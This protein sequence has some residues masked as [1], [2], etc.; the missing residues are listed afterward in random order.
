[1]RSTIASKRGI[2]SLFPRRTS[3]EELDRRSR[4][5]FEPVIENTVR[6]IVD[7]VRER[8]DPALRAYAEE[9]D[10]LPKDSDLYLSRRRLKEAFESLPEDDRQRLERVSARIGSF[11]RA[12]LHSLT[13]LEMK[14]PGGRAGHRVVP[15]ERAGCYAP[16]GRYPLPSSVLMTV[17]PAQ[18]AGVR[19]IWVASPDQSPLTLAAA[20]IAGACGM[21]AAGGAHAI[22]ALAFG[23]GPVSAMDL[24]VGPGN[25]YVTAAKKYVSGEVRIDMLAG[26]SELV[27][28][29]DD[30]ADPAIVAA[31]LLAQAEH[32]DNAFPFLI[33]LNAALISRVESQLE[34]QLKGLPSSDTARQALLNGGSL[35]APDL[36]TAARWSDELAPEHLQLCTRDPRSL[37][38]QLSHYGALFVG[39]QTAEV[40]GDYGAGPNHVLPTNG[41]SRSTGGLSVFTFLRIQ[42]WMELDPAERSSQLLDDGAWFARQEGLEAHARAIE[43]RLDGRGDS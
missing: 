13:E 2:E 34:N 9:L 27:I 23:A 32:D 22:A 16:G 40:M 14:I 42:T 11:A 5:I 37:A 35:L 38:D 12:Q 39:E 26:P 3:I 30:S 25:R 19:E 28:I 31:D 43:R 17:I 6:E 29:A 20:W 21:L 24:I 7:R 41:T 33:S 36:N 10:G 8:G 18:I 15:V 4:R 1:M